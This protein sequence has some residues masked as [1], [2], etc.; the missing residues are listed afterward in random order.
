MLATAPPQSVDSSSSLV[1]LET[2]SPSPGAYLSHPRYGSNE[3]DSIAPATREESEFRHSGWAIRRLQTYEA[4]QRCHVGEARLDRFCNCGSAAWVKVNQ[5]ASDAKIVSNKCHDRWCMRCQGERAA[6]IRESLC[7]ILD[8]QFYRH[9]VLT[10]RASNTPLKD[11]IDRLY[12]SFLVLRRRSS[13][14]SHVTGGVAVLELKIGEKSGMW[15]PHLHILCVGSFYD[16]RELSQ[17]WH[18]VTG[19]SS[20]TWICK[21]KGLENDANYLTKYVT[22]PCDQSIYNHRAMFDELIISLRG[23]RLC[24]TFGSFRG[25]ELEPDFVDDGTWISSGS[26]DSV[27]VRAREG[28]VDAV[29]ILNVLRRRYPLFAHT[30]EGAPPP[31]G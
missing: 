19:D 24:T 14:L 9:I 8:G 1:P 3:Y 23:R 28:D 4:L 20:I 12:R 27:L 10:L 21:P 18:A 5:D 16:Q 26:V 15:H 25:V 30:F 31:D 17:E 2:T 7:R 29:R 11:Q 6:T 22:K 13:W